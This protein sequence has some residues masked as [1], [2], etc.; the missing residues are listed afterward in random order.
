MDLTET[1]PAE[2]ARVLNAI[3]DELTAAAGELIPQAMAETGLAEARLAGEL[4]RTVV[5]LRM[6]ADVCAEGSSS[7]YVSTRPTRDSS[8]A[9]VPI[10]GGSICRWVLCWCSPRATSRSRSR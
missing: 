5:Q 1:S 4:K 7:T 3:A 2:R 10:C 9:P 6:F 8:W